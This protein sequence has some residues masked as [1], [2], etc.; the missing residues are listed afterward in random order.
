MT[1]PLQAAGFGSPPYTLDH[2][3][4]GWGPHTMC[5]RCGVMRDLVWDFRSGDGKTFKLDA[6]C[7]V[8]FTEGENAQSDEIAWAVEHSIYDSQRKV[9]REYARVERAEQLLERPDVKAKLQGQPHPYPHRARLGETKWDLLKYRVK[10]YAFAPRLR[11]AKEIEAV[12]G[13]APR[14]TTPRRATKK[15][16]VDKLVREVKGMLK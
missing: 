14:L 12:A 1:Y 6:I 3:S 10:E 4:G 5:S 7:L 2:R 8:E 9:I 16:R 15:P 13:G 11:A